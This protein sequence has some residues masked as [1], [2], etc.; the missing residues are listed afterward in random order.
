MRRQRVKRAIRTDDVL[1]AESPEICGTMAQWYDGQ[2]RRR[3]LARF[4]SSGEM[5]AMPIELEVNRKRILSTTIQTHLF[6]MSFAMNS[7]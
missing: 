4:C 1:A 2:E 5:I 7:A 3:K 6:C